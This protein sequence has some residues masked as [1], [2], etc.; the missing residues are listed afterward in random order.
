MAGGKKL[1][2]VVVVSEHNDVSPPA[3]VLREMAAV[4]RLH[5]EAIT[6]P[7]RPQKFLDA[8][9]SNISPDPDGALQSGQLPQ[10]MPS[11]ITT[12]E[13]LDADCG[14]LPPDTNGD[15]G[16][17]H[18]VQTVNLEY[19]VFNKSGAILQPASPINSIWSGFG[20]D[21]Q[22]HNDGDP[23]VLYDPLANRWMVSQF[24]KTN[25]ECIAISTSGDP[26]GSYYRYAFLWPNGAF[27]DYPHFGVWPDG[28]YMSVNQFGSNLRGVA[29]A[30][31][32]ERQKML[33][34]QP[35]QM[36]Y[37]DLS[38]VN[39]C[40]GGMLP[41]DVDGV[42][43]PVGSPNYFV[44]MDDN[45][46]NCPA[47]GTPDDMKIWRYHVDW[48]NPSASTFGNNGNPSTI[49]NTA[50]FDSLIN[51]GPSGRDCVP[52]NGTTEKLD[53]L[54]WV[55][56]FRL[57][58]R[59]F[60][61][62]E[63]LI[64][65][66]T[67][68][69]GS[70]QAAIRWYEV[71]NPGGT[72]VIYQ[73]GTFA[74]SPQDGFGRWLGSAAMDNDGNLAIGYS[75]SS[76][77]TFPDIRY[78]GR[79]STDPLGVLSQGETTMYSGGGS[80]TSTLSR[81]GDYSALTVDPVNDCTFWFTTE[82]FAATSTADWHTRVGKFTFPG[83]TPPPAPGTLQ[84]T[85]TNAATGVPIA[86]ALVSTP[87]GYSATTDAL[88]KYSLNLPA[89]FYAVTAVAPL[90]QSSTVNGV[91]MTSA[92]L[93]I[94]N[95]S[96]QPKPNLVYVSSELSD[97]NGNGT[98]EVDECANV[99]LKIANT[100]TGTATSVSAVLTSS[101]PDVMIIQNAS[102][103]PDIPPTGL[104]TN[105]TPFQIRTLNSFTC[106]TPIDLTLTVSTA[107]GNFTFPITWPTGVDVVTDFSS[108]NVPKAL[109][110]NTITD[111]TVNVS[112]ITTPI[113]KVTV[114]FYL[115]DTFDGNLDI[116]LI[117]PD[118]TSVGLSHFS[119]SSGDNFGTSCSNR[120]IFDDDA[121]TIIYN[122]T[123]PFA[124]SYKPQVPLSAFIGKTGSGANGTWTLRVHNYSCCEIGNIVCWKVTIESKTCADANCSLPYLSYFGSSVL[125]GG[126]NG[127]FKLDPNE[128]A[129]FNVALKNTGAGAASAISATLSTSTPGVTITQ[130][131]A[132][133]PDIA[134]G[135]N[136]TTIVPFGITTSPDFVCGTAVKMTLSINS[137]Q[138]AFQSTFTIFTGTST[139]TTF[140]SSDVPKAIPDGN[141]T[142][143][144]SNVSVSGINGNISNIVLRFVIM[145]P[146]DSD[147]S[148]GLV[149]PDGSGAF[150][151]TEVGND[152]DNFGTDCPA[153]S[154]DTILS[155]SA[156]V[157]ILDA[158][159][160]FVGTFQPQIPLAIFNG[161][162]GSAANGTWKFRSRDPHSGNSGTLQCWSMTIT[163]SVCSPGPGV[164][165]QV[166]E[167]YPLKWNA[168]S[169]TNV[170]WTS[171][172]G[173]TGYNVYRG[174]ASDLP[175]LLNSNV[176]SCRRA[177]TA[178]TSTGSVLTE[179]PSPGT[180]Y[181]YIAR[182][183]NAGGE[184]TAGNTTS[185]P[186]VQ[187]SSGNCP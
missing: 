31:A 154:N 137:A 126:G 177:T 183:E 90:Y 105:I 187:N 39:S 148:L 156:S 40:Y 30:A 53:A 150:L 12:F 120:T 147:L 32:F 87:N 83:C 167:P 152:Q 175:K 51:C 77:N 58:Y 16:P 57:Q 115:T 29:G 145:H 144:D 3:R 82:Y 139:V 142:G 70:D 110:G 186:R 64:M 84:G 113:L 100:G 21:C 101:T 149:A 72:P 61:D 62:H 54:T 128:C 63:S 20:G 109:P 112:G 18:Y 94:Q 89:G 60:G 36:V 131:Y 27:P 178:T 81:W 168:G 38:T 66:H 119:G 184:G 151:V 93:S 102:N 161:K 68:D 166:G 123:P 117:G 116:D 91:A 67:V 35:A 97:S 169:K 98:L 78:A 5:N 42:P 111:S 23:V 127:N 56:M 108:S 138:G 11:P 103:Y 65:N 17:N 34:G 37:F 182:A 162:N 164:C 170:N 121:S 181:W 157:N 172:S 173:S 140:T 75:A 15:V 8:L 185:G 33:I 73:Q 96:L 165:S 86:N 95:F 7:R 2:P 25:Y 136:G 143:I 59:N 129:S 9:K 133:F 132:T 153:S 179:T 26:T 52:Q 1:L 174:A 48:N 125:D 50:T 135:L 130:P 104:A 46:L 155:D 24:T 4:K 159:A 146:Y 19:T 171:V 176:D 80:Q 71:R 92:T 160:P 88:G 13:G 14:C 134:A 124:G 163:D 118:G 114:S 180:F 122:G 41:S 158:T 76:S 79:L 44:E 47:F 74:G 85:V 106:G 22:I 69:A 99:N 28:Y 10:Q 45:A 43:P 107:Q 141:V 6:S 55:L 49:L